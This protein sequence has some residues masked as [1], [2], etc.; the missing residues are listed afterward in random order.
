MLDPRI[1]FGN[2]T[3]TV[4]L[5]YLTYA[6]IESE[7]AYISFAVPDRGICEGLDT[8]VTL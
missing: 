2:N 7:G 8:S 4:A 5:P 3:P 6:I 1:K